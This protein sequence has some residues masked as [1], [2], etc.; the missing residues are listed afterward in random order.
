MVG[1]LSLSAGFDVFF[2]PPLAAANAA[3]GQCRNQAYVSREFR[4]PPTIDNFR[5]HPFM[6]RGA[7]AAAANV[8]GEASAA[9]VAPASRVDAAPPPASPS[10]TQVRAT[11]TPPPKPQPDANLFDLLQLDE[12]RCPSVVCI[13][14]SLSL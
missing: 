12:V 3:L 8:A 10:P 13:C 1:M 2:L 14:L 11:T 9:Q 7:G 5:D 6:A 4:E